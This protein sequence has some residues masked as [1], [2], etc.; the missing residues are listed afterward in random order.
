MNNHLLHLT[1]G[2]QSQVHV[3]CNCLQALGGGSHGWHDGGK[4]S[5]LDCHVPILLI[6][7]TISHIL[8][9]YALK[10]KSIKTDV[11]KQNLTKNGL[12]QPTDCTLVVVR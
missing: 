4:I 10:I 5:H 1:R 7:H 9:F 6:S 8:L 2:Q 12:Q 11:R 3:G